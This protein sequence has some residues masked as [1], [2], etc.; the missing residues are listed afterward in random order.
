MQSDL[1]EDTSRRTAERVA[2]VQRILE[3]TDDLAAAALE[4]KMS[5]ADLLAEERDKVATEAQNRD[6]DARENAAS[7]Q[8]GLERR[9]EA[10]REAYLDMNNKKE[11]SENILGHLD[12]RI[13]ETLH[14]IAEQNTHAPVL[15]STPV[16]GPS[17]TLVFINGTTAPFADELI[18]RGK[19]GGR[20]ASRT[21][22]DYLMPAPKP[23]DVV[24]VHLWYDRRLLIAS[25]QQH[26]II[27]APSTW[28]TFVH[29]FCRE[30]FSASP[31]SSNAC[32]EVRSELIEEHV[33]ATLSRLGH[34][35]SVERIVLIGMHPNAGVFDCLLRLE[36]ADENLPTTYTQGILPR[37][38]MVD[39]LPEHKKPDF[40]YPKLVIPGEFGS[41][42]SRPFAIKLPS[43]QEQEAMP[44]P[45]PS[46]PEST[47]M[48]GPTKVVSPPPSAAGTVRSAG[49]RP[50][51]SH[52]VSSSGFPKRKLDPSKEPPLCY[53]FYLGTSVG[54]ENPRCTRAHDYEVNERQVRRFR[55]DVKRVPCRRF[56]TTGLCGYA[57]RNYG[58]PCLFSQVLTGT[59]EWFFRLLADNQSVA[60][61]IKQLRARNLPSSEQLE[62][63][64]AEREAV[65]ADLEAKR[66]ELHKYLTDTEALRNQV[67][68]IEAKVQA[69]RAYLAELEARA[70]NI[71]AVSRG[72]PCELPP[73]SG[74]PFILVLI[75]ASNAPFNEDAIRQGEIGGRDMGQRVR[76]EV[77]KDLREHNVELDEDDDG[78]EDP[79]AQKPQPAVLTYVWH[80]RKALIY[81]L[82]QNKVIRSEDTWDRFL[83]GF[84][85]VPSN[86]VMDSDSL[87]IDQYMAR[88]LRTFGRCQS[89]KRI[90]LAGIHLESLYEACPEIKPQN[91]K[92][93]FIRVGPQLVLIN[94]RET[95][96]QRDALL[97]FGGRVTTFLRF[98]S[99]DNG[100]GADLGWAFRAS[101]PPVGPGDQNL[102]EGDDENGY[103][104]VYEKQ[105]FSGGGAWYK[106][107]A[108]TSKSAQ[109]AGGGGSGTGHRR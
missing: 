109:W 55:D 104:P 61:E 101:T 37:I 49:M 94:H 30:P 43:Q 84:M 25:L 38:E 36:D 1:V 39:H 48:S 10:A 14:R 31:N 89:L 16:D 63:Q 2:Q 88:M 9:I 87:R 78:D 41:S 11:E 71:T 86:Q 32:F 42:I 79:G 100:L 77:E 82:L 59:D 105:A 46:P 34:M 45:E 56:F 108:R 13:T 26:S 66:A 72:A 69:R 70:P 103:G 91:G 62:A 73:T 23:D 29:G 20:E 75:D 81:N 18:R 3:M 98:F 93:F 47:T 7:E 65:Q 92:Q 57:A 76:W 50:Q 35:K 106:G 54:C 44:E 17:T 74:P 60:D 28:S 80:N 67:E 96:D 27:A 53:Y 19:E 85:T 107:P 97:S 99:S 51:F 8:N 90:Y 83:D 58:Q 33:A 6:Q 15:P 4:D 52:P 102:E 22:R 64:Q 24:L 68:D 40:G 95:D 12:G 21:L 5:L